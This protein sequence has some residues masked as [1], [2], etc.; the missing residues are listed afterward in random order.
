MKKITKF[1]LT[2]SVVLF[3]SVSMAQITSSSMN[4]RVTD[5]EGPV[6]GAS[7][8]ATHT[9]S[10]TTYGT[11]T[12]MEG[13]YN[14][15]GMRVGGPYS[16][17]VAYLG[18]GENIIY[19]VRI[20]LGA[21]FVHNV[22]LTDDN[23]S[24]D[25]VV[26]TSKRS[27]FSADKTGATTNISNAE[28]SI[29]PTVSR[30]ITDIARLSP[31]AN[32]MSIAGGDGRSTN[33]TVDG[34][35]FN[36]NFGL[37]SSLPGGGSPISIDA[38][39]EVQVVIAPFDV[40]Q[41]NF[42]G[43]GINAITKSGNNKF[44]GSVYTYFNNQDT[45]GN[46]I[47]DVDFGVRPEE[48][49]TT[50]GMTFGGPIIKDK[51]FFF[52]N[53][54]AIDKPGQVVLWRASEDGVAN[55]DLLNS[56][57]STADMDRVR[58]HLKENY[59][60]E[61]GSYTDFPGDETNRKLLVRLDWNIN[62]AH[63]LSMR[64]NYAKNQGWNPTNGNSND[65]GFRNRSMDR[66][67][68]NSMAF[69]NSIYSSDNNVSTV[70]F[71]L[72]SR[73][74]DKLSNQFLATYSQIKD[75]RGST[76]SP[77]PFIDIMNGV[78]PSGE[79]IIEPYISAGYELFTWNNAVNNNTLTIFNNLTYY[80][81]NHKIVAGVSFER[82][83]AN[84]SFMRNG[85]GYYRYASIDDF[86]SQ[87]APRDFA[88]T[89]GYDG[90]LNPTA[91]VAF[92]QLGIYAQDDWDINEN[93]KLSYGIRADYLRYDDNALTNNSILDLDFGGT[94]IDTGVWP[95]ANVLFS[96]RAGFA[97][98]VNGDKTMKLR[99]G[100][101]I[102][103]GRLPLVFFTNMPTN[104][105]MV[106]GSY[107]AVTRYN[108]DGSVRS[109]D[110][111]LA[112]L[113]GPIITDVDEMVQRLGLKNTITPEDG[114]L[115]RD[116]NAVDPNFKMPQVWKT[117]LALD[118]EVPVNFPL[119]V[120]VEGIA[121]RNI[122]GVMLKNLNL[123]QPDAT[124]ERFSGSD[125]R[126]MYPDEADIAYSS[127]DAY[128]LSNN[129]EGW[130]AISNIT[131]NAEPIEDLKLMAAY[132][133]TESQ[134][135]SGMPG[136]SARSA[137]NGLV[138]INGPHAPNLERSQFVVP[139]KVI[140]SAS[141]KIPWATEKFKS[142]TLINL[143]Y[144]GSAAYA[145]SYTYSNDMNNDGIATDL[146]YIP[147][148]RGDVNFKTQADEDAFFNFMEQ[149]SYL[150]ANKGGYAGANAAAAPWV[151]NFDLRILREY[152]IKAGETKNTLQ[153]SFDVI[154]VGNL[155][156]TTWGVTQSNRVS[157]RGQILKYEGKNANNEPTFSFTKVGDEYVTETFDYDFNFNQAWRL[158]VGVK[159]SF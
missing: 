70:S 72:N 82:Q 60:Y 45:R 94:S 144:S 67:S 84:N 157:N 111:A 69:S 109:A 141:Y 35:N 34:A 147:S 156:N 117:S 9:P 115:P 138:S 53:A 99:G 19:N 125:N 61:T 31:Y 88:L 30:S 89:Y 80:S 140:A 119:F 92:N 16:I 95:E 101:G 25:E 27:N 15:P 4:G 97:W 108:D 50:Y 54:E 74:S 21:S 121:T 150:K 68:E 59:G 73:F 126:Y 127:K 114:V 2:I 71:D 154:N 159:Y 93:F 58:N 43:G 135:I 26:I 3:A 48:S 145:Y 1:L 78:T 83:I 63:K 91:E 77:F 56:R 123:E 41:T 5:A 102:F 151:H 28:L 158:Q 96:P 136:S 10:G 112:G 152:Y 49:T 155:I 57:T 18:Y 105:G 12:N 13:R 131:V 38:I 98:D 132:T 81:D 139:S 128:V 143:F 137:Y 23:V 79:Q 87:A 40:R 149:D 110:S 6:F 103:T 39:E 129:S 142:S 37:S 29:M 76:S 90:E 24:L 107:A 116:I 134:E 86:L 106:Q 146:I 118:Y 153:F 75:E 20:N 66:I 148:G 11:T 44:K 120:T 52:L 32:G 33:F 22:V 104:S 113:A 36:N 64:Y 47:D 55:L 65:A 17:K 14:L 124:W 62:D 42:I 85:R 122:N 100:T 7:V 130:G 8:L 51:L 133:Y 46:R